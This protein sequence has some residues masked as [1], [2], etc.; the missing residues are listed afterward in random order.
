[1]SLPFS[2]ANALA[3][4][5]IPSTDAR[6]VCDGVRSATRRRRALKAVEDSAPL[7]AVSSMHLLM[8]TH[9]QKYNGIKSGE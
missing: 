1:M 3:R 9:R 2:S 4:M 6:T 8:S 7:G 5:R